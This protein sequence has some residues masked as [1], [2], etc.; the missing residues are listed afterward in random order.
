MAIEGHPRPSVRG[1]WRYSQR[2][3]A[4]ASAPAAAPSSSSRASPVKRL[5]PAAATIVGVAVLLRLVFEPVPQL[6]RA[7]RAPVGARPRAR[8]HARLR[9]G[10]RA[11]A[12][13]ARDRRLDPRHAVR[14]RRR[15][16]ADLG[17][18]ALLRAAGLA[19]LPARRGAVPPLGRRRRRA[20]G[21]LA[22]PALERD[23]LLGYQDTAFA[24]RDRRRVLLEARRP[25]RGEAVLGAARARRADAAGG[26]GRSAASTALWMW[27][28]LRPGRAGS[29]CSA[30][31]RAGA[32]AVGGAGLVVTGDPLHSLHGT[33]DLAEAVDRRREPE[34]APYWT[35]AVLRLH[36]ARADRDRASPIGLFFA[37]RFRLRA[38]DPAARRRRR[39]DA[40]FMIGPVFGLPLIGRYVRTPSV[41]LTLFY[42]LAV[43]RLAA[44]GSRPRARRL[45][46]WIGIARARRSRSPSCPGTAGCSRDLERDELDQ[47][48][49]GVRAAAGRRAGAR[50]RAAPS[51]AA[52][53]GSAP[54][55]TACCRTCAGGSDTAAG[56]G[57]HGRGRREPARRTCFVAAARQ[58]ARCA[59]STRT[60]FPRT[61]PPAGLPRDLRATRAWRVRAAPACVTRLRA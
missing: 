2:A 42:G 38:G 32:A 13:S 12:A 39:D 40:V 18:P 5:L 52:A 9:G 27:P 21:R 15:R 6:R 11:H 17:D 3:M 29:G 58:R 47:R 43:C 45:W 46:M 33:A 34:Q 31:G 28:A 8:P 20:R 53:A 1:G 16:A 57:Q 30:H 37:W 35:A 24:V 14:G 54:P 48:A 7:L 26:A 61:E 50:R 59:A 23:A 56:R 49:R 22:R 44:A 19:D 10:L 25:R 4:T 36:P 51:R 60:N 55:T 41:L